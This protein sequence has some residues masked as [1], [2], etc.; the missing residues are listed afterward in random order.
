MAEKFNDLLDQFT[1]PYKHKQSIETDTNGNGM[2]KN[3]HNNRSHL[4]Q[5][6]RGT[7][8]MTIAQFNRVAMMQDTQIHIAIKHQL[9]KM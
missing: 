8:Q 9:V 6:L 4:T 5:L 1:K 7:D 2:A 3:A